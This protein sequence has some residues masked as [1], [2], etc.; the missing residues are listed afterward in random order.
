MAEDHSNLD[1]LLPQV[2]HRQK[3]YDIMKSLEAFPPAPFD[4]CTT[5]LPPQ[6]AWIRQHAIHLS[7]L[8][9]LGL[10]M[11]SGMQ[12]ICL[13]DFARADEDLRG[14]DPDP[15]PLPFELRLDRISHD[16]QL[17]LAKEE[18]PEYHLE[19]GP[20]GVLSLESLATPNH[21]TRS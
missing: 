14:H 21:R 6:Y 3:W 9:L 19:V 10:Y 11:R 18:F 2:A 4:L 15:M 8:G 5:T 20:I 1:P 12:F 7:Q 17:A 13:A 16:Y